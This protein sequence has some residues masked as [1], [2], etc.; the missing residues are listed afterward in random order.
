MDIVLDMI[1]KKVMFRI[2]PELYSVT[3]QSNQ[4]DSNSRLNLLLNVQILKIAP[5]AGLFPIGHDK[6]PII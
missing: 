2:L 4:H 3:F 6:R 5:I 1:I